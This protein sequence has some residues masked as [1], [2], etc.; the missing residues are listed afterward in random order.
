MSYIPHCIKKPQ[1]VTLPELLITVSLASLML[2]FAGPSVTTLVSDIRQETD[3]RA[4][5]D[6][7]KLAQHSA[8]SQRL[9]VTVCGSS[10]GLRCDAQWNRGYLVYAEE[11]SAKLLYETREDNSRAQLKGNVTQITF[12]PSGILQGQSGSL[13]YCPFAEDSEP[14]R[15]VLSRGGRLRIYSKTEADQVP[16]LA[17]MNCG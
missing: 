7:M 1:G 2:T 8:I 16:G 3:V 4:L 10:D 14:Q 15:L 12:R 9:H 5:A 13:L 11:N 17:A 6:A